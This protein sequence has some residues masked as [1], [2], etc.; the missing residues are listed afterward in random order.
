MKK[1]NLAGVNEEI[2]YEKLSNGLDIY[3]YPKKDIYNNYVTF[4]TKFGSIYNEFTPIDSDK[5][6]KV[7]YGVAHFLEHKVFAQKE[8]P[9]PE[10]FF[11]KSGAICNAYTTFK[12]TT[13]L[14]SGPKDLKENLCFLLDYVQS[15]YF[16]KDNVASEKGI[17]TQEIHMCDDDLN[18]VMYEHIRRNV[19]HK[20]NFKDSIIGTVKDIN[21]ITEDTLYTCY[22]TFYHPSNMFLVVCGDFDKEEI[23]NII[24]DNQNK[25]VFK[26]YKEIKVKKY[27]EPDT[28]VK[29]EEVIDINTEIPKVSYNFKIK[30]NTDLST[31]L[32]NL[33]LFVIFS[34]LFDDTSEFDF[35]AKEENIISNTLYLNL[36][37]C[38]SHILISL[39]NETNKFKALIN[40]INETL[41]NIDISEDDLERKKKVLMSNEL[42]SFE[43]IEVVNDM[44]VD[45]I[46]FE[47]KIEENLISLI[48]S[49]N[50]EQLEIVLDSL[51]LK[52]TS[53]VVLKPKEIE[54]SKK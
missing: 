12:N 7:P 11:A 44:I 10:D 30:N 4:T 29:K 18:D 32:F 15:P 52:N 40:K 25:K 6:I 45:N 21:K 43:N 48:N 9:Q 36:L 47:N 46:I 49:L 33:Y 17:I 31:R 14:F 26:E 23:L 8:D 20:N 35:S 42:F 38:D 51:N 3:L 27:K 16:T 1:I 28:V 2:Y 53:I 54:K 50:I 13:Y 34:I 24:M 22:N 5:M 37:N 19:F 39:I 41:N